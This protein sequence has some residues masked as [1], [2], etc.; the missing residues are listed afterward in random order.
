MRQS[1]DKARRWA[2]YCVVATKDYILYACIRPK[3]GSNFHLVDI[4][5]LHVSVSYLMHKKVAACHT[6]GITL[7]HGDICVSVWRSCNSELL[8]SKTDDLRM[9]DVLMYRI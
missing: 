4:M 7:K 9:V 6:T 5:D 8:I 3:A 2:L 1:C